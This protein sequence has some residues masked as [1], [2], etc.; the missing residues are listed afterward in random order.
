MSARGDTARDDKTSA[1]GTA[2]LSIT[3][4]QRGRYF[5]AAWWS[6]PP[7]RTPFRQ[8]DASHGGAASIEAARAEAEASAGRALT[9][10]DWRW[11][12]GWNRILRGQPPFT[13]RDL[14]ALDG[15]P[16][17]PRRKPVTAES[18]WSVLGVD[19]LASLAEIKRAFRK[20]ALETHPDHGGDAADFRAVRAAYDAAIE[21]RSRPA[22]SRRAP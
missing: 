4:T 17:E 16:R 11:A 22:R 13:A 3:P 14:A 7:T 2:L 18:I 19:R 12:H 6:G 20:R 5:W 1:L 21:R 9:A 15:V 10:I 8:P